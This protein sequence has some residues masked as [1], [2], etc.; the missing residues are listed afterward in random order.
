M[1]VASYTVPVDESGAVAPATPAVPNSGTSVPNPGTP[2][3]PDYLLDKFATAEEQAKAYK[4]LEQEFSRHRQMNRAVPGQPAPVAPPAPSGPPGA[5]AP[6]TII[7]DMQA[8]E[9]DL[10]EY[11]TLTDQTLRAH[12]Q[13]GVPPQLLVGYVEGE[14]AKATLRA[15]AVIDLAGGQ[16]EYKKLQEWGTQNLTEEEQGVYNNSLR[17]PPAAM[18]M[19]LSDLKARYMAARGG[20][21][22]APLVTAGTPASYGSAVPFKSPEEQQAAFQDKRYATDAGFRAEVYRRMGVTKF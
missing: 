21:S 1:T 4:Q 19:A 3:R 18:K 22:G 16:E 13:R 17:G 20:A 8:L 7:V 5:P 10:R 15:A 12:A 9:R 2:A 11:G 14:K 6:N